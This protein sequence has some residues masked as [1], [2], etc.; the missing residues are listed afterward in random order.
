MQVAA[1]I[2]GERTSAGVVDDGMFRPYAKPL[3]IDEIFALGPSELTSLE[4][5]DDAALPLNEV[6]LRPPVSIS[7][8]NIVCV[9]WNYRLH[10]DE[11]PSI[12]DMPAVPTFF[13]K[14]RTS[15][16]GPYDL[17]PLHSAETAKLDWE[18]ELAVVIGRG[19]TNIPEGSALDHVFGYAVGNDITARD[20][21]RAHGGQ[22]FKGKSLDGTCPVGPWVTTAD[23]VPDPHKLTLTCTLNGEVVQRASTSDMVFSVPTIIAELSKGMTL[24]PGDVIL[25]GTPAGIGASRTPPRFLAPA[26]VLETEID[27][28]GVIRNVIAPS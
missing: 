28:L 25:T 12:Q 6:A 16:T 18:G 9:G 7:G 10:F 17:V 21:Q 2:N 19:G 14:M 20:V 1:Q 8:R 27:V 11:S 15:L 23:Q 26:D 3:E 24:V 13:T 22:W 5:D 4:L